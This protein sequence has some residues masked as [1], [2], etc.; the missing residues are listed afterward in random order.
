[1][2]LAGTRCRSPVVVA[3]FVAV[4]CAVALATACLSAGPAGAAA[5]RSDVLTVTVD[6]VLST[7]E[8]PLTLTIEGQ[9]SRSLAGAKLVVRVKGPAGFG[10]VG[11]NAPE[12]TEADKIVK[13]LGE[14]P[15]TTTTSQTPPAA[16]GAVVVPTTTTSSTTTTSLAAVAGTA[17]DLEAGSLKAQALLP[18]GMPSEPGAYQLVVEVKSGQDVWASGQV[19]LGKVA[20]RE[21]PLDIAFVWPVSLGIHRDAEGV[22]Y[23]EV[24][25]QTI[26]SEPGDLQALLGM[27]GLFPAWRFSVAIEPVLLTQLRDM[28]DGYARYDAAGAEVVVG[29]GDMD[30]QKAAAALSAFKDLAGAGSAEVLVSPYSGADLG[31]LAAE[32]WRD[33]FEQ[34]QLGKQE[35]QQ[36]LGMGAPLTGA[37]APDLAL[38]TDS[39][40]YYADASI[41]HIVVASSLA[42]LL[43]EQIEEGAI[44]VRARDAFNDRVTLVFADQA[45]SDMV[46]GS[47]DTGVFCAALAAMLAGS[48]RDAIVVV[49]EMDFAVPPG[50]FLKSLGKVLDENDWLRTQTLAEILRSHSPGTRPVLLKTGTGGAQGYIEESLLSGLRSAHA[51]VTDLAAI[52][53]TTRTSVE[54]ARRLLYMAESRWWSRDGIDPQEASIGLQYSSR[55]QGLAEGELAK[56]RFGA[57]ESTTITGHEGEV[58]LE[59]HNDAAYPLTVVMG[60]SGSGLSFPEGETSEVELPPGKTKVQ[61]KVKSG[62]GPH[63]LAATLVAGSSMLDQVSEPL[64][65][66]AI[67]TVLPA[68]IVGGLLVLAGLYFLVRLLLRKYRRPAT[69]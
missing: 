49:P 8:E 22:Y 29:E 37:C 69:P 36:T 31:L 43:T 5:P 16:P 12:L 59:I 10:Q 32:G 24:L 40:A 62:D 28:A 61:V 19:W 33:G 6:H 34:V 46:A 38:T 45:L 15:P 4:A 68:L 11:E 21:S 9:L 56:V 23:D 63:S 57:V 54:T 51:A 26:A 41:D 35:L 27:P 7:I 66:I 17:A 48:P 64:R 58:G 50:S 14:V 25:E 39:V 18:A 13:V 44:A 42:G 55:A 53:D 3:V 1:M 47:W 65:F 30:A 67:W 52:A 2:R 60:L 20:P